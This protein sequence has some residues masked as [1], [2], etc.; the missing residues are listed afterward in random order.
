MNPFEVDK[1]KSRLA[2]LE[3]ETLKQGYIDALMIIGKNLN[4]YGVLNEYVQRQNEQSRRMG[5]D[6]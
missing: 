5:F 6:M 1:L 3:K 2:D 4:L